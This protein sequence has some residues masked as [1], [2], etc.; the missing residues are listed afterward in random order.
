VGSQGRY[1]LGGARFAVE[2][3]VQV[4][5]VAVNSGE[6][7]PKNAFLKHP[8]MIT[9]S[10]G[11]PIQSTGRDAAD[12]MQEVENWIE[13]EMRVLSPHAY[14]STQYVAKQG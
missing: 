1:K 7:W 2:T 11:K 10:I 4:V 8:G 3:G 13:S 12:L 9:V 14:S 6:C 5:P